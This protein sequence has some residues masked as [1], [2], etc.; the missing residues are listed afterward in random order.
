MKQLNLYAAKVMREFGD[1]IKACTDITG[2]G[3]QGHA[4]NLV[5]I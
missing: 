2:F 1:S 5:Q 4:E 3:L